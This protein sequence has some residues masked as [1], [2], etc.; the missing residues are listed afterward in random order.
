MP[1]ER[2]KTLNSRDLLNLHQ[3]IR[4]SGDLLRRN[5]SVRKNMGSAASGFWR[6][7]RAIWPSGRKLEGRQGQA[8]AS[9]PLGCQWGEYEGGS[10]KAA[11][12]P[13][14]AVW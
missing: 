6:L 13:Q 7:G 5:A 9:G 10:A 2:K 8:K 11:R 3:S 4:G 12:G 14:G 1:V